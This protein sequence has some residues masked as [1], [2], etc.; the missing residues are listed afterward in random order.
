MPLWSADRISLLRSLWRWRPHGSSGGGEC[1]FVRGANIVAVPP[2]AR[3]NTWQSNLMPLDFRLLS[4][5]FALN[6]R[7]WHSMAPARIS[8]GETPGSD[9]LYA[10]PRLR[11]SLAIA[12]AV[13]NG[14]QVSCSIRRGRRSKSFIDAPRWRV[15]LTAVLTEQSPQLERRPFLSAVSCPTRS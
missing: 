2:P 4:S 5:S 1:H 13:C 15:S 12:P 10:R 11:R 14:P 8:S 6:A 3:A 7:F 9:T